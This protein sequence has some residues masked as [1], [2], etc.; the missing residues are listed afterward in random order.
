MA[1]SL[2]QSV[3]MLNSTASAT[4]YSGGSVTTSG[5]L[6]IAY[7]SGES[8]AAGAT[9]SIS[10][11]TLGGNAM[12]VQGA[13]VT[14]AGGRAWAAIAI[15]NNASVSGANI[16]ITTTAIQRAMAITVAEW[17]GH[18]TTTPIAQDF[19]GG[20]SSLTSLTASSA[21]INAGG[22]YT[23]ALSVDSGTANTSIVANA[24]ETV[25]A[26]SGRTG[27]SAFSDCS[28][29]SGYEAHATTGTYSFGFN[30]TGSNFA[31]LKVVEIKA[32]AGGSPQTI[33]G[34][35]F[36]DSD[37]FGAGTISA[38]Y[39]IAGAVFADADSFG[40]GTVS[41]R[42]TISG[43]I[44]TDADSF[45]A[46]T[47]TQTGGS[48]TI[49][50]G[51]YADPDTFGAG[52]VSTAYRITGALYADPDVFG[53]GTVTQPSAQTITGALYVDP[54]TFGV[55]VISFAVAQQQIQGGWGYR[56]AE[57][58]DKR[59]A[60]ERRNRRDSEQ[61]RRRAV[62]R[63]FAALDVAPVAEAM[64]EPVRA[65]IRAIVV[66]KLEMAGIAD[67]LARLDEIIAAVW[68]ERLARRREEEAALVLLL[69][70]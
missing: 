22:V 15:L 13:I 36:A 5:G 17:T 14:T 29:Q 59:Q 65:D 4:T 49:T 20:G 21:L 32:A 44:Y 60:Q 25:F 67:S 55:N 28:W 52:T 68:R 30:W 10:S 38:S 69:A 16:S 11:L 47:I 31:T 39:T 43:A 35:L 64:P 9:P 57:A 41:S 70:S 6:A 3:Q 37:S 7:I 66:P 1:V 23:G 8:D 40:A 26:T 2:V 34:A 62:E 61:R 51:L 45:G 46:G 56:D 48:Q 63:A 24:T 53:A 12:T 42:Y 18:D 54:D 19:G 58:A 50:G 33:T 27:T